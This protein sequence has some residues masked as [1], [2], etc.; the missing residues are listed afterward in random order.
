MRYV[1]LVP[2]TLAARLL[3]AQ[4]SPS[5]VRPILEQPLMTPDAVAFE[6]RQYL[7]HKTP[8]LAIPRTSGEWNVE[9]RR[10]RERVLNDVVFHGWPREWV[11][12]PVK[13]E[14]TGAAISG[15][16][17]RI[18]KLRYEIVPGFWSAALVY[19]PAIIRGK[20]PAVLNVNG[21]VGPL[22]KAIEY[23]QKRCINQAKMGVVALNLEWFNFGELASKENQHWF[24]AHLDLAGANEVGLFFLEMRKGLDY[25]YERPDVDRNRIGVT[26]LSG[27]GW[28]TIV[29]SALDE[30]VTVS[31]PVAGYSAFLS[32]LERQADV[33]DLEQNATDLLAGQDYPHLTAMRA[34]RPTLLIYNA[35]DDC[36][37][38]AAL[39][40]P[41]IFDDVR[42]FYRLF[43]AEDHLAWHTNTDPGDHNYQLDNRLQAYRFFAKHFALPPVDSEVAQ[44]GEIKSAEELTV[45]LPK[46]NLT[47]LGLA[48]RLAIK[49]ERTAGSP[50]EGR[51]DLRRTL[52][53]TG[54]AVA[55]AWALANTRNK[56]LETSSYRFDFENGLSATAVWLAAIGAPG[57]APAAILLDDKG[58]KS[59][60][61]PASDRVNRG[62]HVLAA[63]LLFTGD[64]VPP[65]DELSDY[66]QMLAATGDR[67][68]GIEAAQLIALTRWFA[69]NTGAAK[70]RLEIAGIR[71]QLVAQVAA[72]LEPD[73]FSDV[74]VG[75]GMKSLGHLLDA[76]VE[77][78]A[79]PDLFCLDLYKQFDVDSLAALAAP[80]R[81]TLR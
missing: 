70:V 7:R 79:A 46:D 2:V 52:R 54:T 42:Q 16:G 62:E 44:P 6:L 53:Y 8:K 37:F 1:T 3:L 38:R 11:N 78:E 40:K 49:I 50:A 28:Q 51:A 58:K 10:I 24:G 71:S 9:A 34:P 21:H 68:L 4:S 57:P 75:E 25:L 59:G 33:G 74:I 66:T 65:K 64:V 35:E 15:D 32:R 63:D 30:R 47:I 48:R 67:P 13:V 20:A 72:A 45:G 5:Q 39:V 43:N 55:N 76:P 36:C 81:V 73:L 26:G 14:E 56:G 19:E 22:G 17:Y 31:I 80:A 61:D 29:L 60:A 23:K 77:Y 27:G 41:Y 69:K 12:A 18:R